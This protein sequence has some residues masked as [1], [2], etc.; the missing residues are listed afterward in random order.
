V[1]TFRELTPEDYDQLV[2]ALRTAR[3]HLP[4]SGRRIGQLAERA[5]IREASQ[6]EVIM[7]Q[8]EPPD[9]IYFVL[10]GQ[11]RAADTSGDQPRLLNYHATRTFAGELG[12]VY[13]QARSATVDVISSAKLACWDQAAFD[14]LLTLDEG[15]RPYFEN[16]HQGREKRREQDFPGKQWDEVVVVRTGKHPLMLV[17]AL[18]GPALVFL[19]SISLLALL[20]ATGSITSTCV[21]VITAIPVIVAVAWGLHNYVDWRDDEYIVT[22]KRVIHIERFVFY[23]AEWH[24]APLIRIQDI[25]LEARNW[26]QRTYDYHD[27]T[28]QTAGAGNIVFSGVCNAPQAQEHIF[29]ERAKALERLEAPGTTSIRMALAQRMGLDVPEVE[30]PADTP[31]SDTPVFAA[32][33]GRRLPGPINYFYPRVTVVDGDR[34]TWRKHWIVLLRKTWLPLLL[35]FVFSMA[36]LLLLLHLPPFGSL[37]EA[38]GHNWWILAAAPAAAALVSYGWYI[39]RYDDWH[40]DVYIVTRS[41]IIDVESSAF[42]L[43]GETSRE[44]TF[45]VVQNITYSI[46]GILYKLLNI[47][48][49]VIETAGTER[50]FTFMSVFNPIGVQQEIFNRWV[51]YQEGHRRRQRESEAQRMAEW[52]GEY[53]S[54]RK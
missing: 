43:R 4:I 7:R 47:G 9:V 21:G 31:I 30:V 28:I 37:L 42:R 25:T 32:K 15:M 41:R 38:L 5:R 44:G 51:A 52:I 1:S 23:G 18:A 17:G 29:E 53:D 45:G 26:W 33:A 16:L 50:T 34:I 14:W 40:R 13:G 10:S 20:L 8:G 46:P 49:V 36:T 48:D 3:Q 24:E 22:S 27:L 11:L 6:G 54:M 39:L 2:E 35:T 12:L 19:A